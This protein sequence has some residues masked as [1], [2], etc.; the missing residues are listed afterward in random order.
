MRA[1]TRPLP[2]G[3]LLVYAASS[4]EE[5]TTPAFV[6]VYDMSA[7]VSNIQFQGQD[8]DLD[9][10]G[11]TLKWQSPELTERVD[12]Y[13]LYL[14]E[15]AFG[16]RRSQLG[17]ELPKE[18]TSQQVPPDTLRLAFNHFTIFTKSTLVAPPVQGELMP[19]GFAL[20]A[21]MSFTDEDLDE[22]EIG[23]NLTW[24]PP[25]DTS[26][27]QEAWLF[28]IEQRYLPMRCTLTR[29]RLSALVLQLLSLTMETMGSGKDTPECKARACLDRLDTDRTSGKK[30]E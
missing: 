5:Q 15:N 16:A 28:R 12:V 9:H 4:L 21:N 10:L 17:P 7:S 13:V 29:S 6:Q 24:Y 22:T 23:G 30:D 25:E 1:Y 19:L 2:S 18:A 27:V 3:Y 26:E 11:G 8:L 20:A 14:A